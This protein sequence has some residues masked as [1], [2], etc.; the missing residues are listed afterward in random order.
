MKT[1]R[2]QTRGW[3]S[4]RVA[5]VE[6]GDPRSCYD[7]KPYFAPAV[8]NNPMDNIFLLLLWLLANHGLR[9]S[10]WA[11]NNAKSH[12]GLCHTL[13]G[14]GIW[15]AAQQRDLREEQP[16]GE[17]WHFKEVLKRLW[18]FSCSFLSSFSLRFAAGGWIAWKCLAERTARTGKLQHVTGSVLLTHPPPPFFFSSPCEA[19][20]SFQKY[21]FF[22]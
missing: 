20:K 2:R 14:D 13:R 17:H 5:G 9:F 10:V 21:L 3:I 8:A 11:N 12:P 16:D 22:T 19:L 6:G 7:F 15:A 4:A 1:T 18:L